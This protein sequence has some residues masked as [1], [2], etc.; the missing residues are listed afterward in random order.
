[1][2]SVIFTQAA[3]AESIAAQDWY[4]GEATELGRRFQQAII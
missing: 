2:Y 4:A 1:V 3:R